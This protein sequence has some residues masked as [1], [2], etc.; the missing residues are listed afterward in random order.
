M[1]QGTA[2]GTITIDDFSKVDLRSGK[3]LEAG[4]VEGSDKMIRLSVDMGE[5]RP[6]Q[7]FAGIREAYPDPSVLI[8]KMV[9]VVAN[10]KARQMKFGLSEGMILAGSDLKIC[11]FDGSPEPGGKV[12]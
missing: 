10:L 12:S 3:I 8:G 1:P 6:R 2:T 4:L 7:I 11:T 5:T 9:V